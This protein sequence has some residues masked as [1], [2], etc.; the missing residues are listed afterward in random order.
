MEREPEAVAHVASRAFRASCPFRMKEVG[1][2]L[3]LAGGLGLCVGTFALADFLDHAASGSGAVEAAYRLQV[4]FAAND[5]EPGDAVVEH[6]GDGDGDG[7]VQRGKDGVRREKIAQ[8]AASDIATRLGWN[9]G[10]ARDH[11]VEVVA[12]QGAPKAVLF[13]ED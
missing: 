12:V 4:G 10:D 8:F 7:V 9:Y 5:G 13:V 6:R 2:G 3:D 11:V 1:S